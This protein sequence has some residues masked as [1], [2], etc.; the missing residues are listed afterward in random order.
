MQEMRCALLFQKRNQQFHVL[1][2]DKQ[3]HSPHSKKIGWCKLMF[4]LN[5]T[6]NLFTFLLTF[7]SKFSYRTSCLNYNRGSRQTKI[8]L[9]VRYMKLLRP[10]NFQMRIT[11][12]VMNIIQILF[13]C[14]NVCI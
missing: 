7:V 10:I 11:S 4:K 9:K 14:S 3:E 13:D 2:D 8:D 5:K 6:S 1:I 12:Q